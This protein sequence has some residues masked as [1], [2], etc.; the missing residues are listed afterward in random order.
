M[1]VTRQK[2]PFSVNSYGVTL[3]IGS[4]INSSYWSK[5]SKIEKTYETSDYSDGQTNIIYKLPGGVR[6]TDITLSKPFTEDDAELFTELLKV[7]S[8]RKF[9][10]AFIQPMYRDGY[11][12]QNIG[13][14]VIAQ[15][16]VVVSA[17]LI[18]EID[19]GGNSPT[20]LETVLSPGYI[21]SQGS[22]IWWREPDLQTITTGTNGA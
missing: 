2:Q 13:G 22:T 8:E 7:N 20:M 11:Y 3:N 9:I 17:S 21:S 6:F 10:E 12:S 15:F 18:S 1:A 16:C 5:C 19:T 14:V 4:A